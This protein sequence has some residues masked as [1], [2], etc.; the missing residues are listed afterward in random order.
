MDCL[1]LSKNL[2]R[3]LGF[4]SLYLHPRFLVKIPTK[5]FLCLGVKWCH[6]F[7][8]RKNSSS[9]NSR[10][11]TL[12]EC[13]EYLLWSVN[14]ISMIFWVIINPLLARKW[15]YKNVGI[16]TKWGKI[17]GSCPHYVNFC[18][19]NKIAVKSKKDQLSMAKARIKSSARDGLPADFS[20]VILEQS[21]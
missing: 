15:R 5:D 13:S 21:E 12:G 2:C 10:V 11:L 6:T 8:S 9:K 20:Y 3:L 14:D 7:L 17:I 4:Y 16:M 18:D 19:A 1:G